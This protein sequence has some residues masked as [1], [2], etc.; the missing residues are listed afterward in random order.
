MVRDMAPDDRLD[1]NGRALHPPRNS[2]LRRRT[3]DHVLATQVVDEAAFF[4]VWSSELSKLTR[5]P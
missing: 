1:A 3:T 4:A 5:V 2:A